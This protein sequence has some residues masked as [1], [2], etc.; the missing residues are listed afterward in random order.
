VTVDGWGHPIE[1]KVSPDGNRYR[2]AF[3][4]GNEH[5]GYGPDT[6]EMRV[7]APVDDL[8]YVVAQRVGPDHPDR[9]L[10]D[11][12]PDAFR[13]SIEVGLVAAYDRA[14]GAFMTAHGPGVVHDLGIR[15]HVPPGTDPASG[16]PQG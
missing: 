12:H 6:W 13:I 8:L 3:G 15:G 1:T 16:R 10:L 2:V 11:E 4:W 5:T 9:G 14:V 7:T